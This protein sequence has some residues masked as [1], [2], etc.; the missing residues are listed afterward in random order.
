VGA[1]SVG[2]FDNL[3]NLTW[4]ET[5]LATILSA[6]QR[7]A[8]CRHFYPREFSYALTREA[9][10]CAAGVFGAHKRAWRVIPGIPGISASTFG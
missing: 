8:V 5:K 7:A 2:V 4:P 10:K 1:T 6:C 3:P 9:G